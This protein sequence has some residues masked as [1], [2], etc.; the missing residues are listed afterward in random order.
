MMATENMYVLH[1]FQS[2]NHSRIKNKYFLN[3]FDV[4]VFFGFYL[5][6]IVH[7]GHWAMGTL[8]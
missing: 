5:C 7:N 1:Y 6:Y 4:E 2:K 8:P 3:I